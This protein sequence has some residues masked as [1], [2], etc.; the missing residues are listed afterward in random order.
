MDFGV[1]NV[2]VDVAVV[3]SNESGSV[4]YAW[5]GMGD[6]VASYRFTGT[7]WTQTSGTN[8]MYSRAYAVS[9]SQFFRVDDTNRVMFCDLDTD[10]TVEANWGFHGDRIGTKDHGVTRLAVDAAGGL[11]C[12]KADDLYTFSA[13]GR[14]NRLFERYQ[15]P[16][17]TL[18]GEVLA[19]W[20]GKLYTTYGGA[21]FDLNVNGIGDP[22]GPESIPDNGSEVKGYISAAVGTDFF[23]LGGLYNPDNSRGYL[24]E[25]TGETVQ[26]E[27]GR[28][29]PV[30]HGSI[31]AAVA[32]KITALH[33]SERGAD[34]GHRM[35]YIGYS[36][37]TI[38]KYQLACTPDPTDCTNEEFSTAN[39]FV[40][41]SRLSCNFP[42][43]RKS[44]LNV[45]GEAD[46]FSPSNY[47]KFG[48]RFAASADYVDMATNFDS[49]ESE[50]INFPAGTRATY[51]DPRI[52][53]VNSAL[54]ASPQISGFTVSYQPRPRV[55][56]VMDV[57]I[58]AEDALVKLDG[59]PYR[60]SAKDIA[61]DVRLLA[62]LPGGVAFVD[63]EG[64]SHTVTVQSPQ[65]T[66]A[67]D[68]RGMPR[69]ALRTRLIE[70]IPVQS[71]FVPSDLLGLLVWFDTSQ[72]TVVSDGT[73][74]GTWTDRSGNSR[75]AT[76]SG[77]ARPL[78]RTGGPANRAYLDFDGSNDV[79]ATASFTIP[80]TWSVFVVVNQA[81]W[82][83]SDQIVGTAGSPVDG[84]GQI[85]T[86]PKVGPSSTASLAFTLGQWGILEG[87][88]GE[89]VA[90]RLN[91]GTQVVDTL[92]GG[93]LG[94]IA[95]GGSSVNGG[96]GPFR[97]ADIWVAEVIAYNRQLPTTER[98][99]VEW[100]LSEK[101]AIVVPQ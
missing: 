96:G 84:I 15:F 77:T 28:T 95:I 33:V 73:A 67:W 68:V 57:N 8:L 69:H 55:Q 66:T 32:K 21:T 87:V 14:V 85:D 9:S 94:G 99:Q 6:S 58:I 71:D 93:G 70:Q 17:N 23:L 22:I 75:D 81:T 27:E 30:W 51:L 92:V 79:L 88:M 61:D 76:G 62:N 34:A 86:T 64:T 82:T 2:A 74:I 49:G 40:Y 38:D 29:V 97:W 56:E 41:L 80:S 7:T 89:V 16:S 25:Y 3:Q 44:L 24:M 78:Y 20:N 39:G 83:L 37:G 18:N 59:T 43:I 65:R 26:D 50:R 19:A 36:D 4:R 42:G 5:I 46:N 91:G 60:K 35:A 54:T 53:L 48:Y 31:T 63:P 10:P 100:Y 90:I 11:I 101:Y 98:K 72:D 12:A 13:D 1:G 45:I 47:A 52:T